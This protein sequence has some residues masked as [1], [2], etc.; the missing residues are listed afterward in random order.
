MKLKLILTICLSFLM[1]Q[2]HA[3]KEQN[4]EIKVNGATRKMICYTPNLMTRNMPLFIITH[5]MNQDPVYQRDMDKFYLQCDTAKFVV[6][7]LEGEGKSWDIGGSKDLNFVKQTIT[8]LNRVYGIDKNRVYWAGF[9]MGS[10]LIYH[11]IENGMSSY[12]AAFAPC[13]GVKFSEPWTKCK[14]PV[15]LIHCHSKNDDVFP[16]GQYKP[17]D[18]AA[19][20]ADVNKCTEYKKWTNAS[21]LGSSDKGDK[22]RWWNGTNGSEV[23]VYMSN[24]GGHWPSQNYIKEIWC[25]CKRFSLESDAKVFNKVQTEAKT[26]VEEWAG[27]ID[28]FTGL[29]TNYN[30]LKTA[31]ETYADVD[32]ED[33]DAMKT[34]KSKLETAIKNFNSVVESN[35]KKSIKVTKSEFDP[36]F[37]I[38]L[39]FGQSNMEGNATPQMEDYSGAS[40]RF[41][42]M[43][44]VAMSSYVRTKNN[45][46][47]ARPPLCRDNT[48]LTPADY[49]GKTLIKNLPDSITVGVINVALGGCA[50][51]MFNE[52]G[53]ADYIKQQASWLQSYAKSYNNNPFRYLVNAGKEAQKKGVIKGILLHQGCSNNT[54]SDWP[55]KVNLIYTRLLKELNLS[56]EECPLLVGELLAQNQGGVCYGHN[57]VIAKVPSVIDGARVVSSS[58]CTGATDGLHF[59]AAGYRKIGANYAKEMLQ[60]LA[61]YSKEND[62]SIRSIK[63]K[64]PNVSMP[65]NGKKSVFIIL[66]DQN[67]VQHDVTGA[68][69]F[70]SSNPDVVKL[71]EVYAFSGNKEGDAVV[72]ATFTNKEG[73]QVSVEFNVAVRLFPL[74]EGVFNPSLVKT[75]TFTVSTTSAQ[76][77][78]AK[79]GIGG[80]QYDTP[81]DLSGYESLSVELASASLAK[82][83]I[84][85]YDNNDIEGN[86]YFSYSL[87]SQKEAVINLKEMKD[88]SGRQLDPSHIYIVAFEV[89]STSAV[90]IANVSVQGEATG[91][92]T[93]MQNVETA[94]DQWYD[95]MGRRV[96]VMKPGIYVKNGKKVLVK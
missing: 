57:S 84:R 52:D 27:D 15:N 74:S 90:K 64:Y 18:Y 93:L 24:T 55:Q 32:T 78:S 1:M 68:C 75:G 54:Q 71:D 35:M 60:V 34:A 94:D 36:N 40:K 45:W 22:E 85:I 46:Y 42:M 3:Y 29:K 13:S 80:W 66:T 86:S 53:I 8:D 19:H 11:G 9:S 38:Y 25:F 6:A 69:E 7:Y 31:V 73:E 41:L 59:T 79:G 21:P 82:P 12:I 88:E 37:H 87:G 65:L 70:S 14:K 95:L 16:I 76:F 61:R 92:K 2:A 17:R 67:G 4:L 89:G 77:K 51:E 26:L 63:A 62:F 33:A 5:G 47:V 48:G 56:Q 83:V 23:E 81:L 20:F 58:G 49:F 30:K 28:I 96:V 43:A 72:T 39:C 91:I 44:P 10:M 50:I